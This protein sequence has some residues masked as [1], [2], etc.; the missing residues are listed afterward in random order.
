VRGGD[1]ID[2]FTA[3]VLQ[4]KHSLGKVLSGERNAFSFMADVVILAEKAKQVAP[5]KEYGARSMLPYKG[6]FLSKV[7]IVA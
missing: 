4:K 6:A 1:E 2:I 3:L 7:R 5:R